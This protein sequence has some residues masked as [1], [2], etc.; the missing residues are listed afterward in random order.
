LVKST[1]QG[2]ISPSLEDITKRLKLSAG[3]HEIAKI[4]ERLGVLVD[5]ISHKTCDDELWKS[6]TR[7][8]SMLTPISHSLLSMR[9]VMD[10]VNDDMSK[11]YLIELTR[12]ALLIILGRLNQAFSFPSDELPFLQE[13]FRQLL[14]W[15]SGPELLDLELWCVTYVALVDQ[16]HMITY[17]PHINDLAGRLGIWGSGKI[18]TSVSNIICVDKILSLDTEAF[19]SSLDTTYGSS[20]LN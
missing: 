19:A 1:S 6:S 9:R 20:V 18:L 16:A 10:P 12:V 11:D 17:V 4:L 15:R 8:A 2:V 14:L 13:R 5:L 7:A 3:H